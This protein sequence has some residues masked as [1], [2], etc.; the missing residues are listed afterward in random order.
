MTAAPDRPPPTIDVVG[1]TKT[2][3]MGDVKVEALRGV[4]FTIEPGRDWWRSWGLQ[5][6]GNPRP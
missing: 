5:V 6:P 2:Y 4:S 1:L 3:Q